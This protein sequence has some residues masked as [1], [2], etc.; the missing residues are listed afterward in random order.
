MTR[1]RSMLR[2][3]PP[4]LAAFALAALAAAPPAGAEL[5][6]L[7]G[8]RHYK[9]ASYEVRE[10]QVRVALFT[11][12]TVVL[13]LSRVER[14]VDDEVMPEP[15]PVPGEAAAAASAFEWR[16]VEGQPVPETAFGDLIFDAA[17][18]HGVN[19]ALVAALVRAESAYDSK[20]IS[21]KGAQGLMQ[22]MPAT[23]RR[24]GLSPG[25]AFVPSRNIEAGTRYLAWLLNRFEGDVARTLAAYNAGEGTVDRYGGVPPY[26]E[27]RTYVRRIYTTLGMGDDPVL[28]TLL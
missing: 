27:T 25:E 23:A 24:F 28:A 12:G 13:P 26:R 6:I 11:G 17:R 15:E 14:I 4:A 5:V 20:A 3:P 21:H 19:P 9:A 16:F 22:L 10:D 1:R 2:L 8:G 7:E 18:R